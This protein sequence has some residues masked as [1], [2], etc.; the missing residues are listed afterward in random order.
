MVLQ[1][2]EVLVKHGLNAHVIAFVKDEG[3]NFS[4]MTQVLASIVSCEKLGLWHIHLWIHF[5]ACYV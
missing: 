2:N 3:G 4:T 1:I 5:G